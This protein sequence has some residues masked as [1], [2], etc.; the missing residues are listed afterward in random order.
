MIKFG[1]AGN[2]ED[3]YGKGYKRTSEAP[4]YL[5]GM[6][7]DL[8]EYSFGQGV[9]LKEETAKAIRE[10]AELNGIEFS[11]HAPY[12]INFASEEDVKAENSFMYVTRSLEA[13]KWLGGKRCVFHTGTMGKMEYS[14]AVDLAYSRL[15]ILA[16]VI[17]EKG[18]TDCYICP[19][20]M[21]K[22]SQIGDVDDIIRFAK[23]APFFVP[24]IDFGHINARNCGVLNTKDDY[25][26]ILDKLLDNLD[27]YKV[28][29]MHVHF[30][31]IEYTQAG[32]RR[33]LTFDD[34]TYGPQFEPLAELLVEYKLNPYIVSESAGTQSIDA[35]KMKLIYQQFLNDTLQ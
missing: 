1:P 26:K 28:D 14:K 5:K 24:A 9:S 21:G 32:E 31:K 18:Y 10:Q 4:A 15:Q 8:F 11:V 20:T 27:Y 7:L 13:L 30:S 22:R 3:F 19:E 12:Y 6:G 34:T 23:I 16:E 29:E 35:Q 33:H 2:S 17:E 25:R